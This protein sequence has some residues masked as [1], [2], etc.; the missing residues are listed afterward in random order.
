MHKLILYP[1]CSSLKKV[2]IAD[3]HHDLVDSPDGAI[4]STKIPETNERLLANHKRSD[5]V[6][7]VTDTPILDVPVVK[8]AVS[9]SSVTD[10][11]I[12]D[13]P[14]VEVTDK[15]AVVDSPV[16]EESIIL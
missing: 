1:I 14:V 10:T 8:A 16:T 12:I 15:P 3:F 9:V 7:P 5:S 11:H 13:V 2:T 6:F 4:P